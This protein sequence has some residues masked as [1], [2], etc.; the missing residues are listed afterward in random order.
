[1][2]P[3]VLSFIYLISAL[4][5]VFLAALSFRRKNDAISRTLSL[6]LC[7]ASVWSFFYG[8]EI[9]ATAFWA[10]RICLTLEYAGIVSIPVL[11]LFYVLR[12]S[13][14]ENK[15]TNKFKILIS[16]VP[17]LTF[18]IQATNDYQHLFYKSSDLGYA[19]GYWY[20]HFS[21][22]VFY[23]IHLVYSYS[24]IFIGVVILFKMYSKVQ[25]EARHAVG[26]ILFASLI[27]FLV[28]LI[29]AFGYH[30]M[31]FVDLTPLGFLVM[32]IILIIGVFNENIFNI[33]PLILNS[34]FE[35][36]PDAIFTLNLNS[37]II[38]L[39]PAAEKLM[40]TDSFRGKKNIKELL[41]GNS[42]KDV[43]CPYCN[44]EADIE[45]KTYTVTYNKLC[46]NAGVIIGEIFILHD[47][48]SRIITENALKTS[49]ERFK[50]LTEIFP[51]VIYE[52]DRY[53]NLTYVNRHGFEKFGFFDGDYHGLNIL[54]FISP[55]D[56][57]KVLARLNERFD[58][59]KGTFHEYTAVKSNGEEFDVLSYTANIMDADKKIIGIRGF[60]LDISERKRIESS[61]RESEINFRSFFETM[62]D[63]V[64]ICNGE[65]RI[66]FSNSAMCNNMNIPMEELTQL[67]VLDLI[68]KSEQRQASITFNEILRGKKQ[69][70]TIPFVRKDGSV[71]PV[72]TR[73]WRGKW[74]GAECVFGISKDLTNERA[75]LQKFNKIF[76]S[77]PTLM[78]LLS[79]ENLQ[80]AEVNKA[81]LQKTGYTEDECIGNT[82]SELNLYP[83]WQ[84]TDYLMDVLCQRGRDGNFELK[85]KTKNNHLLSGVL[86]C[87]VIENL[88]KKFIL[89]VFS[90]ITE[91][92]QMSSLQELLVEIAEK[93]INTSIETLDNEINKSLKDVGVFVNSDRTYIYEKSGKDNSYINTYEWC[94]KGIPTEIGTQQSNFNDLIKA[95]KKNMPYVIEDVDKIESDSQ[96]IKYLKAKQVKSSICIP[97]YLEEK[98]MGFVGF[99]S[100]RLVHRYS[101][102][103][104]TLLQVFAQMIVNVR[105][106]KINNDLLKDQILFQKLISDISSDFVSATNSNIEQKVNQ[107]LKQMG[108]FFNVDRSYL[109]RYTKDTEKETNTHEWCASGISSQKDS[110]K[111]VVMNDFPWWKQQ[112]MSKKII[113]IYDINELPKEATAEKKDFIRQEIQSIICL[114]IIFNND[115]IGLIGFDS[116]REK[117]HWDNEQI[118]L[119]KVIANTLGDALMRAETE[120]E[121]I[122]AK[123]MAEAA[124]VAKT[125]FLS[126]MS[127]EIRTP[128]NGVIGFTDLLRN[129]PLTKVQKD[130]L[131]NA[132]TSANS[133]LGV[134]SDILDFSKI[135]AG[136]LDLELVQTDIIQLLQ[137]TTDI[138]KVNAAKKGLELLLNIQPDMP[139]YVKVDPIRFKQILVNLIGN[140]VKFTNDGEVELVATF[141]KLSDVKV[142]ITVGIRDTGIGI[143]D[144]DKNKLFKAFS[145]ADT[146]TTRR[147]GG[148]G[149]GLIISNSLAHKMGSFISFES[150]YKKGSTFRFTIE[151]EYEV[152]DLEINKQK[153][154]KIRKVMIVDD[155]GKNRMILEHNFKFWGIE[156]VG[157]ESG[158]KV[159]TWLDS[160]PANDFDLM[161][162]DYH[163]PHLNGIETIRALRNSDIKKAKSLPVILLH[164]SA[165]NLSVYKES[166][167][168]N[169]KFMLTKPVKADE[170]FLYL[171]NINNKQSGKNTARLEFFNENKDT[172]VSEKPVSI[173]VAEDTD[174]NMLLITRILK[175]ILPAVHIFKAVNGMDALKILSENKPELIIM[176]VQMPVMDGIVATKEI[177]KMEHLKNVPVI[178]LSAGVTKEEREVCFNAGMNDF[179]AKPIDKNELQS[180]LYQYLQISD[181]QESAINPEA[182]ES[183]HFRREILLEK[184]GNNKSVVKN[185]LLLAETEFP[186]YLL[187]I[188][189]A[190]IEKNQDQI[191]KTAHKIKGSSLNLEFL[192][193]AELA[194]KI[195]SNSENMK[196]IP[197]LLTELKKEWQVIERIIIEI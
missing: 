97:L 154:D 68:L 188:E 83:D 104:V 47:I 66:I 78:A 84:N 95:H 174:I 39:N 159:M 57:V 173:M 170:L 169:I 96:I 157:F 60:I 79:I 150:T 112:V 89:T 94:R 147:Y 37:E 151:T 149:L 6:L 98:Y 75:A 179:L 113:Q 197:N 185:M 7:G 40:K 101:E 180:K 14:N 131:D 38:S 30:P 127:H 153:L 26:Y 32:G 81:F 156:T 136:K 77:N 145:Q 71:I 24:L 19:F 70:C 10:I 9:A 152:E 186:K 142:Q 73:I 80:I 35:S 45:G 182:E 194:S 91:L 158:M 117:R 116:V 184:T 69:S 33:K 17:V 166:K 134:I 187:E 111:D 140:A 148:T 25:R 135:E 23:Y 125:E 12:Y 122:R 54:D 82:V 74:N 5:S 177:R 129:T 42:D 100:I 16:I 132:I 181:V 119:L 43:K 118:A 52:A 2:N 46:N 139:R 121:L 51:E 53:G 56:K 195:E 102:R 86:F 1:M 161:I 8:L 109:L 164:S 103:E 133:L 192:N 144:E 171:Y 143:K 160:N 130:Y 190:F 162:V 196:I 18:L 165:D 191:K 49:E 128:L 20:H 28:S 99:D 22:G 106:R 137:D 108:E 64:F 92:K 115:L 59:G 123:E 85:M 58:G 175:D 105:N 114:P 63:M 107:M 163:M 189:K 3:S 93:Y 55:G 11:Y 27:P 168:L 138:V 120:A 141:R 146:S 155:N 44:T 31:G 15:L 61:L 176:D 90:D 62:N 21:P 124:N 13:G 167:E 172:V 29:Y 4:I 41:L 67:H 87:E 178:A 34:L 48:T 65:R 110:I 36:I 72:E 183:E 76:D 126:N 88:G 193:L 50:E